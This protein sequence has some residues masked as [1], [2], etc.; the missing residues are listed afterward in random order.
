[1]QPLG[2]EVG[3]GKKGD[4]CR[5]KLLESGLGRAGNEK[6]G[7]HFL[8]R[9]R[10]EKERLKKRTNQRREGI[11]SKTRV[12][13]EGGISISPRGNTLR[14]KGEHPVHREERGG[15]KHRGERR[16]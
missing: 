11:E 8:I 2:D 15:Q 6:C 13:A 3:K 12:S 7:K 4:R 10:H 14:E 5:R 16:N 9:T 1:V